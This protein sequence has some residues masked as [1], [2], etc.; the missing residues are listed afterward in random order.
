MWA[1]LWLRKNED[2]ERAPEGGHSA[3]QHRLFKTAVM[4]HQRNCAEDQSLPLIV[5]GL[6]RMVLQHLG[7]PYESVDDLECSENAS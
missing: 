2:T 7:T 4:I 5:T 6:H 3:N 1:K